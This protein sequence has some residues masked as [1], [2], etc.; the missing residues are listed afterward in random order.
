[1]DMFQIKQN[2]LNLKSTLSKVYSKSAYLGCVITNVISSDYYEFPFS[3][4]KQK[5][6]KRQGFLTKT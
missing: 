1:M 2:A 6:L 5:N 4:S 3:K